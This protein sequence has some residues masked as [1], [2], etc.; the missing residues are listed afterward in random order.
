LVRVRRTG[1]AEGFARQHWD[2]ATSSRR[3]DVGRL[4]AAPPQTTSIRREVYLYCD[5]SCLGESRGVGGWAF[6]LVEPETGHREARAD[7]HPRTT[8]NRMELSAVI[9]AL[10]FLPSPSRVRLVVDSRYVLDGITQRL[11]VWIASQWRCRSGK[12]VAN[13]GLW[14]RL[15]SLLGLRC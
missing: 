6:L 13:R 14:Q 11:P 12:R 9:N 10:S 1:L 15:V 7:S 2:S 8:N 4:T 3:S 5:G